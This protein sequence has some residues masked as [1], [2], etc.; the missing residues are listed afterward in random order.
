M[1]TSSGFRLK[2]VLLRIFSII[3][4][5]YSIIGHFHLFLNE[6]KGIL[7][8]AMT[9]AITCFLI[10]DDREDRKLFSFILSDVDTAHTCIPAENGQVALDKL[11]ADEAFV[12]DFIFLDLNMPI[13]GG[14]E[15]LPELKKIPRLKD[16]PVVIYTTSSN[17]RDVEETRQLGADHFLV[18]PNDTDNLEQILR[19]LFERAELPFLIQE[20]NKSWY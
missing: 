12:P 14:K 6:R 5:Y 16:V 3:E 4:H 13:M 2:V 1:E 9:P 18:K 20:K 19:S 10:D 8:L 17:E 7:L 15:C 11:K